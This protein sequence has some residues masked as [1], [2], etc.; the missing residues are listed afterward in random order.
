[1]YLVGFSHHVLYHMVPASMPHDD[2]EIWLQDAGTS[3]SIA[4]STDGSAVQVQPRSWH[5]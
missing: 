2:Y 3:V 5:S 4:S 1:M